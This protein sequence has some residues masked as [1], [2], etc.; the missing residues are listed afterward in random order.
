[1]SRGTDKLQETSL[2]QKMKGWVLGGDPHSSTA[3]D[4]VEHAR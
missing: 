2:M 1:L 3:E 4:R